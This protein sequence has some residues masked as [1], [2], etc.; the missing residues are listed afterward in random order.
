MY[1]LKFDG[2]YFQCYQSYTMNDPERRVL[3]SFF[4]N[5]RKMTGE[6]RAKVVNKTRGLLF[7]LTWNC[8]NLLAKKVVFKVLSQSWKCEVFMPTFSQ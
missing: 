4:N 7:C 1:I 6:Q 3:K 8:G 5:P 2:R